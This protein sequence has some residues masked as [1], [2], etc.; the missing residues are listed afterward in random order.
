MAPADTLRIDFTLRDL[1]GRIDVS[2]T[3]N[4]NPGAL[5]YSLLTGGQPA[6]FAV[7]FPVCRAAVSYPADGY[8]AVF[9]WTQMV[10]STDGAGTSF[11]MD[12]IA[13]YRD[14]PTPF[15]WYGLKPELFDAPSREA[16]P[17]MDWAAHSFLCISPDAVVSPRVQAITGF[18]WGFTITDGRFTYTQPMALASEAW[19]GHLNLLRASYPNWV[20]DHGY[21]DM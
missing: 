21:L 5:G 20:F 12:P 17:D 8:A 7:D 9:G 14:V 10:R 16:R 1:A 3:R 11:E 2:L 6:E 18:S 19:D 4:T 13:I 15:A